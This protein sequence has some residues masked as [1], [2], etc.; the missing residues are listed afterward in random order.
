MQGF[1][2]RTERDNY[3]LRLLHFGTRLL[4]VQDSGSGLAVQGLGFLGILGLRRAEGFSLE[5]WGLG[6]RVWDPG[7]PPDCLPCDQ[8][9]EGHKR[10]QGTEVHLPQDTAMGGKP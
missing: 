3:W 4:A 6:F 8:A 7:G 9:A 10:P 5:F 1:G 2:F